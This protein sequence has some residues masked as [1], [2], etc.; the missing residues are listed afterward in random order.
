[1]D[2]LELTATLAY[3]HSV[4]GEVVV[5]GQRSVGLRDDEQVLRVGGEVVD[6]VAELA[7]LARAVGSLHETEGVDPTVG[8]QRADQ[9]DVRALRALYR[10]HQAVVR[11]GT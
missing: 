9:A 3:R 4:F 10:A 5:V 8:R 6:V 1:A 7:V 11:A 2:E